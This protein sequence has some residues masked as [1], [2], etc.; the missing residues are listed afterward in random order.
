MHKLFQRKSHA[1]VPV[2]CLYAADK[3]VLY[4]DRIDAFPF[5]EEVILTCSEEFFNDPAPCEIHR[6]AVQIR[7]CGEIEQ[8]LKPNVILS[9]DELPDVLLLYWREL[10]PAFVRL[11]K[12][13]E[14]AEKSGCAKKN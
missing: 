10:K 5:P 12:P 7:L 8:A 9:V 14:A 11:E 2:L 1:A 13:C 3:S 4:R 6:R